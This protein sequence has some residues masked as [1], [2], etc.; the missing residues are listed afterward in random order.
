MELALQTR[1][2]LTPRAFHLPSALLSAPQGTPL[3]NADG[4]PKP[5]FMVTFPYPYMNGRLHLG[6]A[7]SLTK[8]ELC[9]N[10]KR[11][12]GFNVL[13]PFGFHCTGMPIQVMHM[14]VRGGYAV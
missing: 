8:A 3:F 2:N 14:L 11:L 6:H 9:T 13:F 4:S 10:Y 7:F 5:K 1:L 12:K